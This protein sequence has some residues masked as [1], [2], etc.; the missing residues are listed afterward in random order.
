M[1]Q[2][3]RVRWIDAKRSALDILQRPNIHLGGEEVAHRHQPIERINKFPGL[4]FFYSVEQEFP[5][6]GGAGQ[7]DRF[8]DR[9]FTTI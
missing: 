2:V 7:T 3:M 5:P 1:F 9:N 8:Q 6:H 4:D